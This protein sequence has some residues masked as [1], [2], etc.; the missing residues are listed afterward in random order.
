MAARLAQ[1]PTP[2]PRPSPSSA[3]HERRC[4]GG[5][6][7]RGAV[8]I[9]FNFHLRG[10]M[11]LSSCWDFWS[12]QSGVK[13]ASKSDELET[14]QRN[15]CDFTFDFDETGKSVERRSFERAKWRDFGEI[16]GPEVKVF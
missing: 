8:T 1:N 16:D 5:V 14:T 12:G 9:G 11:E 4:D 3:A 2:R 6:G 15:F 7:A 13:I 10:S